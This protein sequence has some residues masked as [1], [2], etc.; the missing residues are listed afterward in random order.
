[1]DVGPFFHILKYFIQNDLSYEYLIKLHTKKSIKSAGEY[2][3]NNWRL[4]LVKSL[5]GS[6]QILKKNISLFENDK[7]INIG[8][9][10]DY[11]VRESNLNWL[12]DELYNLKL[13]KDLDNISDFND[14]LMISGTMFM[15]RYKVYR[16]FFTINE[17]DRIL[18]QLT[19]GYEDDGKI[20]HK[21]E[22]ILSYIPQ[23]NGFK[24][25]E[26]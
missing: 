16:E 2:I 3:G 23:L 8:G 18:S 22:R 21:L 7:T 20:E 11:S 9:W 24:I 6:N 10:S 13:I 14:M 17:I 25:I 5:I 4:G 1:M 19:D 12:A 26:L 15:V